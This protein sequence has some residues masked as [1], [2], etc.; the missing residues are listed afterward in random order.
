VT[1]V[2]IARSLSESGWQRVFDDRGYP[3]ACANGRPCLSHYGRMD[4]AARARARRT[5]GIREFEGR[6]Y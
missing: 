5:V 4:N 1:G 2:V 3:C 6:R